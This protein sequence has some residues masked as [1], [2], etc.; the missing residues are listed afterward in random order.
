[1]SELSPYQKRVIDKIYGPL[2]RKNA[3]NELSRLCLLYRELLE[4]IDDEEIQNAFNKKINNCFY[5]HL[6]SM[7]EFCDLDSFTE[8]F[9]TLLKEFVE[10]NIDAEEKDG[11][12]YYVK[13]HQQIIDKTFKCKIKVDG[14]E[15]L[16]LIQFV[17]DD[18]FNHFIY[19]SKKK[20]EFLNGYLNEDDSNN[21]DTNNPYPLVFLSGE[22]YLKFLEYTSKH[23]I[24]YYLDYSYLKK[25]L[26]HERL[27]HRTKDNEFM[28]LLHNEM[29]LLSKRDY[30]D[31]CVKNKLSSLMKT[32]KADRENNFNNIFDF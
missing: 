12:E 25:R 5:F 7:E 14:Y 16:E 19:T 11:I 10:D 30:D 29:S 24:D 4:N 18:F 3:S 27:I 32:T 28:N 22:I 21:T 6:K 2:E 20:I 26:E 8:L 15:S 13:I 31:Y 9:P 23:I 17:E 1:M